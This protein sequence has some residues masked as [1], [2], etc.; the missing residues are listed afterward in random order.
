MSKRTKMLATLGLVIVIIGGVIFAWY[1]LSGKTEQG[2]KQGTEIVQVD[3]T[4]ETEVVEE[5]ETEVVKAEKFTWKEEA[6]TAKEEMIVVKDTKIY[7]KP[8]RDYDSQVLGDLALDQIG[9]NLASCLS[10]EGV[11]LMWNK[12]DFNGVIGYVDILDVNF[13]VSLEDDWLA[14]EPI[15]E[16]E[17]K[18]GVSSETESVIEVEETKTDDKSAEQLKD[19][20]KKEETK[21]EEPKKEE[22]KEEI[23][24]EPKQEENL[25]A[26]L[27]EPVDEDLIPRGEGMTPRRLA[28]LKKCM[29]FT[30]KNEKTVLATARAKS[31]EEI[32]EESYIAVMNLFIRLLT[33]EQKAEIEGIQ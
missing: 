18:S 10:D 3:E 11:D 4:K 23:I 17:S 21:T 29:E 33:P 26:K 27:D 15:E 1:N 5:E 2:N 20:P 30:G 28:K 32:T 8:T 16:S 22:P 13:N 12:V 9:T 14:N 7:S 25:D 31:F 6:S 19:E 24:E